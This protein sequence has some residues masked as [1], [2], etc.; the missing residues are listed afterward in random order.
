[1][2]KIDS[3]GSANDKPYVV[4]HVLDTLLNAGFEAYLV[5]GC[6]R[7]KLLGLTPGDYD[8][9]TNALPD[10]VQSLF[11][12]TV[13]TGIQHGTVSVLEDGERIEVTTFRREGVYK[14]ARRPSEVRFDASLQE[15]LA[16]RD[17]T[18]NAMAQDRFGN[19]FDPFGGQSDLEQQIIRAV[20]DPSA[21]FQE[22]ALRMLRAVRF[23]AVLGFQIESE[24]WRSIIQH[25]PIIGRIARERIRDE[26]N[27]MV[28]ADLSLGVD[29]LIRSGLFS[30]IFG[31]IL[32]RTKEE[33]LR[34]AQFADRLPKKLDLRHAAL[35]L[36]TDVRLVQKWMNQIRQPKRLTRSVVAI[37][38]AMP[39]SNPLR[40]S[41]FDWRQFLYQH[42]Q[43]AAEQ[44]ILIYSQM[45]PVDADKLIA[46]CL[47]SIE[48]QPI[49]SLAD[50]AVTG[51]DILKHTGRRPGPWLGPLLNQLAQ[52]VLTN[53][54]LNRSQEL[55]H[56]AEH[57]LQKGSL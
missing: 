39:D 24:T 7:D 5:G 15:D 4:Y 14:D 42:G 49:W 13:P 52:L 53:P 31:S 34:A 2:A 47:A 38:E 46:V 37:L 20:G 50:L 30:F 40:W 9:A 45:I 17:F 35:L 41:P 19:L 26:W 23:S 16:R 18:I 51:H 1:M 43:H 57:F 44:A 29:Q 22:D 33:W 56:A 12:H 54:N 11:P 55:K 28:C 25:A 32:S 21:R 27:K 48:D 8:V 3:L 6:V 36:G 10:Q